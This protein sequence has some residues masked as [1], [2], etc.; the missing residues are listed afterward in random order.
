MAHAEELS[1]LTREIAEAKSERVDEAER[2]SEADGEIVARIQGLEARRRHALAGTDTETYEL[3]KT[4]LDVRG[5]FARIP[6]S[7]INDAVE[8]IAAGC[9]TLRREYLAIKDYEGFVSQRSDCR[10]GYSPTHGSIVFR[11]GLTDG[12]I[13][14]IEKWGQILGGPDGENSQAMIRYLL[15][16]VDAGVA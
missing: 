8:D 7:I 13:A 3:A 11:V 5:D 9:L 15:N 2:H 6:A 1:Q 10:Y 12:A 16:L 4:M 14:E